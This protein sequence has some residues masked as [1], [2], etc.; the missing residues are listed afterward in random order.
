MGP[1]FVGA[2]VDYQFGKLKATKT[3]TANT[4]TRISSAD[5]KTKLLTASGRIGANLDMSGIT[6]RPFVGVEYNKGSINGFTETGAGS[7]NLIVDKINA[8]RTD[9]LAGATL[10]RS[11]GSWRPYVKGTY[12]SLIGSTP[13]NAITAAFTDIPT[14]T[15]T[16]TG[17]GAGKNEV[18]VDAGLNWVS[19]DEGGLFI[20]YQGTFRND[21]TSHG[22]VAGIRLEF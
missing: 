9:L 8:D 12:R 5:S 13:T 14:S 4:I 1:L 21:L 18:D 17:R 7:A 3:S 11:K 20:A 2:I 6:F 19:D 16:V 15:F 10:T 22:V